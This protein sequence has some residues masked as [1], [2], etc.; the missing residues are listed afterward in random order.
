M[1]DGQR[2][3]FVAVLELDDVVKRIVECQPNLLVTVTR[4]QPE[5]LTDGLNA[6]RFR[7]SWARWH[8]R[9]VRHDLCPTGMY[10]YD[11]AVS[12]KD[13]L[14]DSL[15]RRGFTVNRRTLAYRT[16]VVNLE[17]PE[18]REVGKGYVYVGQTSRSPQDRLTQHLTGARSK[19][20]HNLASRVVQRCGKSLNCE[21][22]PPTIYLTEAEAKAA[23]QLLAEELRLRG[24]VVEGGH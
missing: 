6:G 20:G 13:A 3:F 8:V 4:R 9:S 7:P 12:V 2:G 22:S 23:E 14:V 24:F 11:E 19:K 18:G 15:R 16:Y 5:A 17:E 21:L 10:G 1:T